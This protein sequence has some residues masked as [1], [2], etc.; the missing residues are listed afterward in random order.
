[1]AGQPASEKFYRR[2]TSF[3]R[4]GGRIQEKY[5]PAWLELGSQYVIPF[6]HTTA[7]D[8]TL[9]EAP[10]LPEIFGRDAPLT[11]EIGSGSGEQIVQAAVA[12][13]ERNF[14]ALEVWQNGVAEALH[15]AGPDVP[16]LRFLIADAAQGLPVLFDPAGPNPLAAEIWTFF[17][18]PWPKNRHR[19][20]RLVVPEFAQKVA[21]ALQDGGIWRLSTDWPDYAWQM[22]DAIEACADLEN[23][24]AG[25]NPMDEDPGSP[26]GAAGG[27]APR[28]GGRV[29][30]RFERRGFNE[31][32]P[33][34]DLTATRRPRHA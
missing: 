17:P 16:N 23:L 25:E 31:G 9:K 32:R 8:T 33:P 3:S 11:V 2:V 29:S 24:H 5:E 30:T 18:D 13:P 1:M 10:N 27:F 34:T 6:E 26:A 7:G 21:D 15:R 12:H 4:R 14:L 19:K 28:W 22:R 20:R